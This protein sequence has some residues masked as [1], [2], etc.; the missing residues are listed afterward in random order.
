MKEAFAA[1]QIEDEEYG[2]LNYENDTGDLS[3]ID[4]RWCLVGRFLADSHIDVQAMQHKM[5]SL[6]RPGEAF[7]SN[8]WTTI[9]SSFSFIMKLISRGSSKEAHGPLEDSIWC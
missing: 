9:G 8:K 4:M 5:A 2:G 7:M 6:W 1:I 3:E